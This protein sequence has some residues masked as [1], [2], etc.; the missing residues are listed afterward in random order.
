[1]WTMLII[2]L[3]QMPSLALSPAIHLIQ[4]QAFPERTLAQVQTVMGM[5]NLF[6]PLTSAVVAFLI[7]RG[8]VTKKGAVV[9]G[10]SSRS[11]TGL[12]CDRAARAFW[13]LT[14]LSALLGISC[15]CFVT[16]AFGLLFDNFDDEMRQRVAG[17][18][19][20]SINLGGILFSLAGDCWPRRCG[21]A[22]ISSFFWDPV[23]V[24]AFFTVP[25]YKSPS[26]RYPGAI[27]RNE[28]Q[29]AHI[30][31][32][33]DCLF[34]HDDLYGLQ[35]QISTHIEKLGDSVTSGILVAVQMGGGVLSGRFFGRLSKRFGDMVMVM[36]CGA[37]FMGYL[38]IGLFSTSLVLITL[39]VFLAGMSLSIMLPICIYSVSTLVDTSN[40]ATATLIISS[41]APAPAGSCRRLSYEPD[42][43]AV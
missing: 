18:Q 23:A 19:T 43:R 27:R 29:S 28:F 40:S 42:E 36:A 6:W 16:N 17:F 26:Q 13:N 3:V 11:A 25:Y 7:N 5:T 9:F 1:M 34:V 8:L 30:L 21:T 38:L 14:V 39:G 33:G 41:V 4:T 10:L 20:S 35:H 12:Y 31:L 15:G 37:V 24:L 2:A 32:R 22:G